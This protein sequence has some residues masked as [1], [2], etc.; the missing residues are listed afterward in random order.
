MGSPLLD[1]DQKIS[2]GIPGVLR[3]IKRREAALFFAPFSRRA[4]GHN[5]GIARRS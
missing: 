5:G 3:W 4:K 1:Y 2:A